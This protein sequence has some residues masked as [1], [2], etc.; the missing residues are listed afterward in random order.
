MAEIRETIEIQASP[1]RVWELAG[2][3]G[4]IG[5]WVPA[6]AGSKSEEDGRRCTTHDGAEIVERVLE[7]SDED[8]YYT[9]EITASPLPIR[10][11]VSR[12]AVAGHDGHA[13][14]D[15]VAEFEAESP[16]QEPQLAATFSQIYRDG[17]RS[18]REQLERT[19]A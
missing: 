9:Y 7:H 6:L 15:W 13:H 12:I 18:L 19:P 14:V 1:A 16:E 5:E 4:R 11:Y 17:L 8:R 2:D 3:A 10:S